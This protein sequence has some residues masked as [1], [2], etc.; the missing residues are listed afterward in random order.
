[1]WVLYYNRKFPNGANFHIFQTYTNCAKIRTYENFS[2]DDETTRFFLL[3][4][5]FI[6]YGTPDV[7]VNMVG[8]YHC[9]DGERSMHCQ[10][11]NSLN[12]CSRG[13]SLKDI[14]SAKITTSK[15]YSNRKFAI[16]RKYAPTKYWI[17]WSFPVYMYL[18]QWDQGQT[19][20]NPVVVMHHVSLLCCSQSFSVH[21]TT[22]LLAVFLLGWNHIAGKF[23]CLFAI[24]FTV[25]LT[26]CKRQTHAP[27]KM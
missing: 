19:C 2:R 26:L 7:F 12:V 22:F 23:D 8:A 27:C 16:L 20:C 18:E 3:R 11:S 10:C 4:Q 14:K 21:V 9:L 6:Y 17:P 24:C 25:A 13:C 1:M 15:F 5:L